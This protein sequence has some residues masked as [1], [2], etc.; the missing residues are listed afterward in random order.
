MHSKYEYLE[1][2]YYDAVGLMDDEAE[3][4]PVKTRDYSVLGDYHVSNYQE[5]SH[6]YA[7]NKDELNSD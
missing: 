6:V 3:T 1:N 4:K 2:I 5:Q 7:D